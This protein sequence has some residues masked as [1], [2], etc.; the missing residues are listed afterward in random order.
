MLSYF[1]VLKTLRFCTLYTYSV[2]VLCFVLY[3][4]TPL[5][6]CDSASFNDVSLL[7]TLLLSFGFTGQGHKICVEFIF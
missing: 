3:G 5:L 4:I 7:V 2:Q 6:V 1:S